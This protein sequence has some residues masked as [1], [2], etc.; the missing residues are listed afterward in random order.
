[1]IY[2]LALYISSI[3]FGQGCEDMFAQ[4][5]KYDG[6]EPLLECVNLQKKMRSWS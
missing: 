3:V 6:W 4:L 5:E 1:M 2:T